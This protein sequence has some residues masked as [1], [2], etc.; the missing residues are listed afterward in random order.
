MWVTY[1]IWHQVIKMVAKFLK[2]IKVN[3]SGEGI[4]TYKD[5]FFLLQTQLDMSVHLHLNLC[6]KQIFILQGKKCLFKYDS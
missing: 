5:F 2:L 3:I 1:L 4:N 6:Y